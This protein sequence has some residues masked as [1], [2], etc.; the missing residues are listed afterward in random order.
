MFW[1]TF[2]VKPTTCDKI[3]GCLELNIYVEI[4]LKNLLEKFGII[5]QNDISR[6]PSF[7]FDGC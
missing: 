4:F 1:Y 3:N 7:P 5:F 2:D 6:Q